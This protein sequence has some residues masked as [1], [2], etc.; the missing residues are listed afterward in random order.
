MMKLQLAC[1]SHMFQSDSIKLNA[2]QSSRFTLSCV[3][4]YG[5]VALLMQV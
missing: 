1:S 5:L 3:F 4:E 2:M